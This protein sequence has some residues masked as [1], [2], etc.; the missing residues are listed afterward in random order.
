M[1]TNNTTA[2][3]I[4]ARFVS[5]YASYRQYAGAPNLA[6]FHPQEFAN[7]AG[8]FQFGNDIPNMEKLAFEYAETLRA[9]G[10]N[11]VIIEKETGGYGDAFL[12]YTTNED[13]ASD[14]VEKAA[15]HQERNNEIAAYEAQ[16]EIEKAEDAAAVAKAQSTGK[17]VLVREST[18]YEDGDFRTVKTFAEPDGSIC[19]TVSE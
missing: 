17:K 18:S 3:A 5:E 8:G 4:A 19:C 11:V 10:K 6:L 2:Q 13:T 14:Y 12:V 15:K 1:N 16:R 9:S 7:A